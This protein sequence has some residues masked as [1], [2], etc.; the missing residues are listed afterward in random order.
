METLASR[1]AS[2][3]EE[4]EF[5]GEW[6]DRYRMMVEWGEEL[7]PLAEDARTPATEVPGCS[8]PLWFDAHWEAG[9]LVVRGASPGILPKALVALVCRLFD[10]VSEVSGS[11]TLL[12]DTLGLAKNLSPTRTLVMERL[13]DR[14]LNCPRTSRD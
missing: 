12:M 10:G 9:A 6:N 8:S 3:V 5:A 13:L 14:A 1:L 11:V 7:E 2:L 4:L